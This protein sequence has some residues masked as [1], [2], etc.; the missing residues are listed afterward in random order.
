MNSLHFELKK[1]FYLHYSDNIQ[2]LTCLNFRKEAVVRDVYCLNH[3]GDQLIPCY[4]THHHIHKCPIEVYTE[5][6]KYSM[7][8]N[9]LTNLIISRN[10]VSATTAGRQ[11]WTRL[12]ACTKKQEVLERTNMPT[13]PT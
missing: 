6:L 10:T 2:S 4:V 7:K 5:P 12:V 9:T 11:E 13:F 8:K 3:Q 1:N